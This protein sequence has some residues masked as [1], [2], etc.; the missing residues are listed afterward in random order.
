[1]KRNIGKFAA[2]VAAAGMLLGAAVVFADDQQNQQSGSSSSQDQSQQSGQAGQAGASGQSSSSTTSGQDQSSQS[3]QSGQTSQ[4]GQ[5]GQFGVGT[6]G[7]AGAGTSGQTSGSFSSTAAGGSESGGQSQIA[8]A[9]QDPQ[10]FIK[11]AYQENLAEVKGGQAAQQKAQ[12]QQTKDFAQSLVQDHQQALDQLKKLADQKNVQ[13]SDQLDARHQRMNDELSS[14]SGADFDKRFMNQQIRAHRRAIALYQQAAQ[15]NTDSDVKQWA[16][17]NVASL[18][19]HLQM[20]QQQGGI[21][22]PAGAG[23]SQ[24]QGSSSQGQQGQSSSSSQD[25]SGQSGQSGQ[26]SQSGQSGQSGQQDQSQ[27]KK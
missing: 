11:M 19:H 24:D 26:S 21:S 25:Q 20:A 22:E 5:S 13:V 2:N 14:L 10:Q 8:A 3:G 6:S 1:M 4:S 18:Q 23:T 12:N 17:Q 27:P 15:S 7:T 9:A 16:Q